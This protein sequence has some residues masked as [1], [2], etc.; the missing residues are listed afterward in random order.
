MSLSQIIR[1][2]DADFLIALSN[3]GLYNRARRELA[4]AGVRAEVSGDSLRAE[5]ADGT[6]LTLTRT[7]QNYTCSC[8]SRVLCKHLLMAV[9]AAQETGAAAEDSPPPPVA[10]FSALAAISAAE[11]VHLAGAKAVR[12]AVAE[13]RPPVTATITAA[14]VLTVYLPESGATT[15]FLPGAPLTAATCSCK[16]DNFCPHRLRAVLQYILAA[17]GALPADF[18]P[19]ETAEAIAPE[20]PAYVREFVTE[21]L[22]G[23]LVRLPEDGADRLLQLAAIC[24]GRRLPNMERLAARAAGQLERYARR[25]A[26]FQRE[27]LADDLG[28]LLLL[29]EKIEAGAADKATVG[30]FRT[31]YLPAPP[32]FLTGLG[33]E[34][35]Q[36]ASGYS[37]V[38]VVMYSPDLGRVLRYTTTLKT[39]QAPGLEKM[40]RQRAPW[41]LNIGLNRL[42]RSRLRLSGGRISGAGRLSASEAGRAELLGPTFLADPALDDIVYDDFAALLDALWQQR[43]KDADSRFYALLKPA[44]AESGAY[45]RINQV[46]TLPL[47]DG[48]GRLL[49]IKVRYAPATRL[50]IDNLRRLESRLA[51]YCGIFLVSLYIE[52]GRLTAFPLTYYGD[53]FWQ[54]GLEEPRAQSGADREP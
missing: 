14:A 27:E 30:V 5:F 47:R 45:D 51:D 19:E 21:I 15:R 44:G 4:E 41:G 24:R 1:A 11:L 29:A 28:A 6:V 35:W 48:D 37:G 9:L 46:Y 2:A 39:A 23:G 42:A 38:T 50:L 43:E 33:A 26:L 10:D 49:S 25:S 36:S 34:G 7:I 22:G 17:K 31:E 3:K 12:A 8:P 32:F 13:T 40:F 54:L 20:A 52:A 53:G 16:A 18:Y